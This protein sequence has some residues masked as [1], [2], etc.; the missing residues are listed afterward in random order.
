MPC[1]VPRDAQ[2]G[3]VLPRLPGT[4]QNLVK[5]NGGGGPVKL[6]RASSGESG[7]G[8]LKAVSVERK[9]RYCYISYVFFLIVYVYVAERHIIGD[10]AR[11]REL[12]H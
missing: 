7:G 5:S 12:L 9:Y 3:T 6:E 1:P 11:I 8:A 10:I 2:G 4:A